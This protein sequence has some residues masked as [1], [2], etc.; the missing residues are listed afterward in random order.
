MFSNSD[1]SQDLNSIFFDMNQATTGTN[2]FNTLQDQR[3][4]IASGILNYD[5]MGDNF[6]LSS[7]LKYTHIKNRS[8]FDFF[9]G[10]S[11]ASVFNNALSEDFDYNETVYAAFAQL[12]KEWAAWSPNLVLRAEQTE[13]AGN[14]RTLG[15]VNTQNY[16]QFFPNIALAKQQNENNIY[17]LTYKRTLDRPSYEML[18]PFSYFINDTNFN[19][20]NPNLAPA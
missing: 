19:A 5:F 18:N 4:V 9:N 14:N 3:V 7:G 6:N 17:S 10:N 8:I 1:V 11:G 20:G 16:L 12:D 15:T 13:I 2:A